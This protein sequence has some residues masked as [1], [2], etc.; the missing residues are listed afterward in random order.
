MQRPKTENIQALIF[1]FPVQ[2]RDY[3][4]FALKAQIK[5]SLQVGE[6]KVS[7]VQQPQVLILLH[8]LSLESNLSYLEDYWYKHTHAQV[9]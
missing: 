4:V 1:I 5:W 2:K 8:V 6:S 7:Q 9:Q 3:N